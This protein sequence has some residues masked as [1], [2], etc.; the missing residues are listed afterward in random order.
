[1]TKRASAYTFHTTDEGHSLSMYGV[2]AKDL[3]T[4]DLEQ[5][6]DEQWTLLLR[7]TEM[8][9]PA[10]PAKPAADPPKEN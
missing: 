9:R 10:E 8:Y 1:M 6:T 4:A 7:E 5:L 2:P 3:D